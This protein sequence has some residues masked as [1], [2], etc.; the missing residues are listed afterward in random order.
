MVHEVGQLAQRIG[1]RYGAG[2]VP[3]PNDG[4]QR[5]FTIAGGQ[6]SFDVTLPGTANRTTVVSI[7]PA[8]GTGARLAEVPFATANVRTQ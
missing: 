8:D 4:S 7:I 1:G 2:G 6:V 5:T 3:T